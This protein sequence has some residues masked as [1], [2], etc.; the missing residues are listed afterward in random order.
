MSRTPRRLWTALPVACLVLA[1][2]LWPTASGPEA[3]AAP[4]PRTL[5]TMTVPAAAFVPSNDQIEYLNAAYYLTTLT[6]FSSFIAPLQ[7]PYPE[8]TIKR[9]TLHAYDNGPVDMCLWAG[10]ARPATGAQVIM[11]SACSTGQSATDPRSFTT[12]AITSGTV[13]STHHA[14]TLQLVFLPAGANYKFYGVTI[15]Y[16]A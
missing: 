8:V 4:R 3:A 13:N 1:M 9:V 15:R 10:R 6:G 5:H 12:T 16:Q 2:A 7:F 11:G 14:A